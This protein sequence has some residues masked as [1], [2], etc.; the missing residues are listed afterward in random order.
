[1]EC[2]QCSDFVARL[3]Q[4]RQLDIFECT[5]IAGGRQSRIHRQLGENVQIMFLGN[6]IHWLS[7][8]TEMCLPQ[9]GHTT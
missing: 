6:L 3:G 2:L 4:I 7:P 9:S 8:N 5:G 1:M